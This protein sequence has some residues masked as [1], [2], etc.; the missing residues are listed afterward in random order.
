MLEFEYIN[1]KR[2]RS[3][4]ICASQFLTHRHQLENMFNT[5]DLSIIQHFFSSLLCMINSIYKRL[6][7]MTSYNN[8]GRYVHINSLQESAYNDTRQVRT[9]NE[10]VGKERKLP[11]DSNKRAK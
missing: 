8:T 1:G 10:Q 6:C 7:P 11:N 9:V 4:V 2:C 3:N 5:H